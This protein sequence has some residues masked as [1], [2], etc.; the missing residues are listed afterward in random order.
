[1]NGL[2][3]AFYL[4]QTKEIIET[5]KQIIK[6]EITLKNQAAMIGLASMLNDSISQIEDSFEKEAKKLDEEG[7]LVWD[8]W[9][10][11]NQDYAKG[12]E[13]VMKILADNFE[14]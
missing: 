14:D 7:Q 13:T 8:E 1:M 3:A 2:A 10:K 11:K 5:M 12:N 9:Y 6:E 4:I